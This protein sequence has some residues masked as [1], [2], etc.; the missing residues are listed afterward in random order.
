MPDLQLTNSTETVLVDDSMYK[1]LSKT[2][3]RLNFYGAVVGNRVFLSRVITKAPVGLVVDHINRNKLD[4]RMT[5]LRI[6]TQQQNTFNQTKHKRGSSK[7]KGVNFHEGTGKWRARINPN[8]KGI[9]LGLFEKEQ[10]A[11][12]AYDKAATKHYGDFAL[13][14]KEVCHR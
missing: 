11:A 7:F 4:N 2:R 12:D 10:E 13:L 5:N 8:R 1:E 14:N 6:C 3:W 9:H